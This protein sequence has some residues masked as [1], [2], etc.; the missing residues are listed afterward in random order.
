MTAR[1]MISIITPAFNAADSIADSIESV[2]E[3]SFHD[4]ELIVVDDGSA[5]DTAT[6]AEEFAKKD[7]R[8]RVL[9]NPVNAGRIAARNRAVAEA[10]G[11]FIAFLDSDDIWEPEKLRK[12]IDFMHEHTAVLSFT[13]YRKRLGRDG[14]QSS[15]V[16]VPGMR[17]HATLLLE[18]VIVCS[19]AI[20]DAD[21][22][23]KRY[24]REEVEREDFALWL[25]ILRDG[26]T[27]F[28]LNEPLVILVKQTGSQSSNKLRAVQDTWNMYRDVENLGGIRLAWVFVN[29]LL[30]TTW[31]YFRW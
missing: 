10:R 16:P 8:I 21:L 31:R 15:P 6:L 13:A 11:R 12:Q 5:D 2:R 3:Q 17:D 20:Y 25:D 7:A 9:R 19:S 28:G 26:H 14:Q 18:N 23:G 22:L 1:P 24:M 30:R 27:A 4:W 29:Y